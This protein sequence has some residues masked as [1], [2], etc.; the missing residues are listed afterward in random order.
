MAHAYEFL[1]TAK[2]AHA[3]RECALYNTV[4]S[5]V[6]AY[7]IARSRLGDT[8]AIVYATI[9]QLEFLLPSRSVYP[10]WR[11]TTSVSVFSAEFGCPTDNFLLLTWRLAVA[12]L[13]SRLFN[14]WRVWLYDWLLL[15]GWF[16]SH[17]SCILQDTSCSM[18]VC[19]ITLGVVSLLSMRIAMLL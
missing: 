5:N 16:L 12:T 4:M 18:I 7:I 15:D 3:V 1:W 14:F 10:S 8:T 13:S 6:H 2:A 19:F 9:H 17:S 11:I